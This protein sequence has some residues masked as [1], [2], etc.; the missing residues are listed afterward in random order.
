MSKIYKG[1]LGGVSALALGIGASS[2]IAADLDERI[3]EAHSERVTALT[4]GIHW[5]NA[6]ISRDRSNASGSET[7]L[8]FH[9]NFLGGVAR[10]DIPMHEVFSLQ[11]DAQGAVNIDG[12]DTS[13]VYD[14]GSLVGVHLNYREPDSFLF[15]GFAGIGTVNMAASSSGQSAFWL[16]G[17]EGQ[18]HL[19]DWSFYVQG[20]AGD[21]E[22]QDSSNSDWAGENGFARG[23][24]RYYFNDGLGKLQGDALYLHGAGSQGFT[25]W[26]YGV[27]AEHHIADYS[28][29]FITALARYEYQQVEEDSN[30]DPID[31]LDASTIMAGI[32]INLGYPDPRTRDRMGPGV[33]FADM[34]RIHGNFKGK[35]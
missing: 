29:G 24:V 11:L 9:H 8:E 15:G 19:N 32:R 26:V 13:E 3:E 6:D 34:P 14:Q 4:M 17:I 31:S 33:D 22:P 10:L 30:A 25:T 18:Y 23:V 35:E 16:A 5:F 2:A 12:D 7:E 1:M 20:G 28:N 21:V 27:E